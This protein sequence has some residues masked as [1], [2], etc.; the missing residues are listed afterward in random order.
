MK[1]SVAAVI[2]RREDPRFLSVRRPQ[3]DEHLPGLWG[4]PAVTLTAGELPEAGLRRIGREK[5]GVEITPIAFVGIDTAERG[6]HRLILMDLEAL[7]VEGLPDVD[8]AT[9]RGTR[10]VA[11]RWTSDVETL[12]EAA[13]R[14]SLC[15]RILLNHSGRTESPRS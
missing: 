8:A 7:L 15:C 9:G 2:R 4:L 13:E 10:Y 5:L 3:D 14:G 12:R 11:Q 1:C 6:D